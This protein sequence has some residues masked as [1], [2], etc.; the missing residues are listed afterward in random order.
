MRFI[1]LISPIIKFLINKYQSN[2]SLQG[3]ESDILMKFK[4]SELLNPS[5]C[6]TFIQII[7]NIRK[8]LTDN[9]IQY[10]RDSLK[11]LVGDGKEWK[12][13]LNNLVD[14][15]NDIY[16][17]PYEPG[18]I[19]NFSNIEKKIGNGDLADVR[20]I[21][22]LNLDESEE[23]YT[24]FHQQLKIPVY[25]IICNDATSKWLKNLTFAPLAPRAFYFPEGT[26]T[27]DF[28]D[29]ML[30][31]TKRMGISHLILKDEY[32]F[33]LRPILPYAVVPASKFDQACRVFYEKVKGIPNYGG[34]VLEEFLATG[35]AI[36]IVTTHIFNKIIRV[37]HII[38]KVKLKPY[39]EGGLYDTFIQDSTKQAMD[40]VSVNLD[41]I[42]NIVA[43]Y[44][45]YL[46]SSIEYILFKGTPRIIDINS[47]SNTLKMDKPIPNL[48][49]DL[50]FKEFI[51]RVCNLKN[52]DELEKQIQYRARMKE[53]Y[54]NLK[55][56][57][58]AFFTGDSLI[59]LI[60]GAEIKVKEFLAKL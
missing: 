54:A 5:E 50:I 2:I 15:K 32:D 42:D 24:F 60:D 12:G 21:M 36:E 1:V 48:K 45:P 13:F 27:V 10:Q 20:V 47:V 35:D 28:N 43:K 52:A 39:S 30:E 44:Y 49:P 38:E 37:S 57:G 6:I 34:L 18:S 7:T 55:K 11:K 16:F 40:T 9:N 3:V 25:P 29:K 26:C 14:S 22:P 23:I 31:L 4:A 19:Q 17:C 46:F 58:A 59:S 51:D 56:F 33:D 53:L 41:A 8:Y